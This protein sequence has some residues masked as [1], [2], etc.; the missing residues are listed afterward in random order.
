MTNPSN[1]E[2]ISVYARQS[3][4]YIQ[5]AIKFLEQEEYEKACEFIW[6]SMA[7][8]MK[9]VAQSKGIELKMHADLW[10]YARGISK[11]LDD[12]N[13]YDAFVKASALHSNFYETNLNEVDIRI[14]AKDV[15][16]I[17]AKLLD[18]LG[19]RLPL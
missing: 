1:S 6:G 3:I 12:K 19:L 2:E 18:L 11:E 14:L 17:V 7:E 16:Q 8:A 9:A 15:A 4:H 13:I 10:K 5:N